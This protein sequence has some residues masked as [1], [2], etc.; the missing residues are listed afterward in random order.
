MNENGEII[1]EYGCSD[2]IIP[3]YL[4]HT[5]CRCGGEKRYWV[6]D[7]VNKD[8][9]INPVNSYAY[10]SIYYNNRYTVRNS[11]DAKIKETNL[12]TMAT[13]LNNLLTGQEQCFFVERHNS[14]DQIIFNCAEYEIT[15]KRMDNFGRTMVD[16]NLNIY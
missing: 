11:L 12:N 2:G 5:L 3:T 4:F 10:T 6:D 16:F 13:M 8:K 9:F 15:I 14:S 1:C 7:L